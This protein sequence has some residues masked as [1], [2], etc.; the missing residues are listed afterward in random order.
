MAQR[1]PDFD[2]WQ[3]GYAGAVVSVF[4]A[5]TTTLAD[6]WADEAGTAPL[7]NPQT[8]STLVVDDRSYGK[9]TQA[10]Y[11]NQSY[12][13][14]IN[15]S[16]QTGVVR[17]PIY[18]LDGED[19]SLA[20]VTVAGASVARDLEDHLAQLIWAEDYG[21]FTAS[22]SGNNTILQAAIGAA[23]AEGGG[24]VLL[25]AGQIEFT[26]ITL[27]AGVTL[28][29][30]GIDVTTLVS[31][32]G[33]KVVTI[34]GDRAGFRDL[35]LDGINLQPGSIGIYCENRSELNFDH[36]TV[37]RFETGLKQI[38]AQ[39][40]HWREFSL[41]NCADGAIL[42]GENLGGL[43][44]ALQFIDWFGGEV[45]NCTTAGVT[46]DFVDLEVSFNR[47]GH[48]HFSGNTIGL[49]VDGARFTKLDLVTFAANTTPILIRDDLAGSTSL[50][51]KVSGFTADR[52]SISAGTISVTGNA[53]DI[54]ISNTKLAGVTFSLNAPRNAL[55]L[56]NCTE[57]ATTVITGD[58][59][60]LVRGFENLDGFT[61]GV[62]TGN[63]A[64][65]GWSLK[66]DHGE[67]CAGTTY[68]TGK[69][70][71]GTDKAS[72]II[73]WTAQRAPATLAYDAQVGNFTVGN[74]VTGQTSGA[75]GRII[76]DADGGATGTL[77][78]HSITGTFV[79]NEQLLDG[80]GGNALVNG[81]LVAGS[82]SVLSQSA[83]IT[84]ESDAAWAATMAGSVEEIEV[85][86]TGNTGKTVDWQ[87]R[88]D[89]MRFG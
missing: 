67:M 69:Q 88:V 4:V 85:Q 3:E 81:A 66:L 63:V 11:T 57:D 60:K 33:N 37:K 80:A 87:I 76:A 89:A 31:V 30:K 22:A 10:V 38:G 74:L 7:D 17:Q 13:L 53:Q 78:L 79:D 35:T 59:T 36:L 42:K 82:V 9:W 84:N 28:V 5:G 23:A 55:K 8:L 6:I 40:N 68:V 39:H 12:Y 45:E 52:C 27:P 50:L 15:T 51:A 62:T 26:Q 41:L 61:R 83:V 21:V 34:A 16:E 1:I 64:T 24:D 54:V 71:N 14:D 58:G 46:F 70:R 19:A 47:I 77:T 18:T 29:G 43:G 2:L 32:I 44:G 25:P 72:Y 65:K 73:A 86:V 48:V 49:L 56:E 75:T 20:E